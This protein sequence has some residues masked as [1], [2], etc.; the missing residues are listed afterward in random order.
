VLNNVAADDIE[1][2][3]RIAGADY[4]EVAWSMV[5]GD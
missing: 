1:N 2:W 4:H 5:A 3:M